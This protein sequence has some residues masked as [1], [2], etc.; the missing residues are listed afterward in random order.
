MVKSYIHHKV[1]G[2]LLHLASGGGI[3]TLAEWFGSTIIEQTNGSVTLLSSV[4]G[5]RLVKL[6]VSIATAHR[7]LHHCPSLIYS[8]QRS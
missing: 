8:L 2:W 3:K 5:N 7:P 1:L 4:P 6:V